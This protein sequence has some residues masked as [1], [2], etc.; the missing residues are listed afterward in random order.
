[1]NLQRKR[2]EPP[3]PPRCMRSARGP[4]IPCTKRKRRVSP[5]SV[6]LN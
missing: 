6:S 1:M 2:I 4:L 3:K 5:A